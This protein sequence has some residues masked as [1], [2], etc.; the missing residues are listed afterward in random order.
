MHQ[1][2]V[3]IR[4]GFEPLLASGLAKCSQISLE[5]RSIQA[6]RRAAAGLRQR[7]ANIDVSTE[8]S[9]LNSAADRAFEWIELGRQMEVKVQGAM[10]DALQTDRD[11][12][13]RSGLV[14]AGE[15]GHAPDRRAHELI[16]GS[17]S[18]NCKPCKR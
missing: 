5:E 7:A 13:L 1:N 17:A 10:I 15:A 14:D 16:K 2:L 12:A 4:F 11:F 3:Q 18:R 6:S 8:N 9:S